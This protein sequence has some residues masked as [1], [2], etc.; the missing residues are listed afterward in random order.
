MSDTIKIG[1][2]P[3]IITI[4]RSEWHHEM[5]TT[6]IDRIKQFIAA[7]DYPNKIDPRVILKINEQ[8]VLLSRQQFS[9]FFSDLDDDEQIMMYLYECTINPGYRKRIIKIIKK[10]IDPNEPCSEK[11]LIDLMHWESGNHGYYLA[12][13]ALERGETV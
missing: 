3:N 9:Y 10:I 4:K 12:M 7:S 1:R 2:K 13:T 6:D 8:A 11:D 5:F